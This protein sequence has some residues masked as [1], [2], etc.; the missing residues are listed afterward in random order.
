MAEIESRFAV[1]GI[2]EVAHDPVG[3]PTGRRQL[4]HGPA[5]M[6]ADAAALFA[7]G[8]ARAI[9]LAPGGA[10][11]GAAERRRPLRFPDE[12]ARL[13]DRIDVLQHRLH[14][15]VGE[16]G[17]GDDPETQT[18]RRVVPLLGEA[19]LEEREMALHVVAHGLGQP[20][21]RKDHAHLAWI[22]IGG[23]SERGAAHSLDQPH[24]RL[25]GTTVRQLGVIDGRIDGD[26]LDATA[27]AIRPKAQHIDPGL[28]D[29]GPE[30]DLPEAGPADRVLR[31]SAHRLE[32]RPQLA[33][34]RDGPCRRGAPIHL[35]HD[36]ATHVTKPRQDEE[37]ADLDLHAGVTDRR[38]RASTLL[39]DT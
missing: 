20:R 15:L 10:V 31:E 6:L 1:T 36:A 30:V 19:C 12:G 39:K 18:G 37:L 22:E 8:L 16:V 27:I 2:K 9:A 21:G 11:A 34:A 14:D 4:G 35:G 26:R 25:L 23:Q 5:D 29:Q 32:G 7:P 38:V 28:A 13:C 33:L 17:V 24:D 3:Q